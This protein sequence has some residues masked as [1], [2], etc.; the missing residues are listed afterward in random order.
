MGLCLIFFLACL[1]VACVVQQKDARQ[2]FA[3]LSVDMEKVFKIPLI[4]EIIRVIL[5]LYEQWK[6]FDERKEMATIL[7]KMPKPKPPPNRYFVDFTY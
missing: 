1:H 6:N 2:W 4:L 7:S 5:K 3:E